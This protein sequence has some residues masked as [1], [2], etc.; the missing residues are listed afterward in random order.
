M[1]TAH[2]RTEIQ[3]L[4]RQAPFRPFVLNLENGDRVTIEHP[5]NIA[6]DPGIDGPDIGSSD[7]YVISRSLRF[8]STFEAVTHVAL[9]DLEGHGD[10]V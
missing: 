6:F 9:A 2:V 4:I 10:S 3:R 8:Y 1:R 5:E 7:F